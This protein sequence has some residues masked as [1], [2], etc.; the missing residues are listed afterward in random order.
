MELTDKIKKFFLEFKVPR[1]RD[2]RGHYAS[3][4]LS[5]LRDQYWSVTG[6][7]ETDPPDCIGQI[8]M[9]IGKCVEDGLVNYIFKNLHFFGLHLIGTQIPVGGSNPAWDG[10]I[11]ALAVER[12]GAK[13]G[14]KY[15][16]EVK[17]KSGFGA[18][19]LMMSMEPSEEYLSQLGLYL[20]DAHDKE[21]PCEGILFYVPL[22]DKNIGDMLAI[23]CRYESKT[24]E[25]VAY[26]GKTLSGLEKE[27]SFRYSVK[28]TLER[29]K[30]LDKHIAEQKVPACEFPYKI[31]LTSEFLA[32]QS[33]KQIERAMKGE[34]VLG[35]W[36]PRYSRYKSLILK[37]DKVTPEY[38]PAEIAALKAEF[39]RR[40]P[41]S[42]KVL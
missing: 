29:A 33:D 36:Q 6:V 10:Y 3:G 31:P 16:I 12:E 1:L 15:A 4:L 21:L 14:K 27:L 22:S 28:S 17:T 7:P 34:L 13:W 35:P 9:W 20:K 41:R 5:D 26:K 18:D 37:T 11:D 40:H 42:K 25:I 24:Q 23:Y 30:K 38:T 32:T 8:K 39:L 2:R 19:L